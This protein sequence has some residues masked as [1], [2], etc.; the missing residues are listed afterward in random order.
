MVLFFNDIEE[1]AKA[2]RL[3]RGWMSQTARIAR[4][5]R[6]DI[7]GIWDEGRND[8]PQYSWTRSELEPRDGMCD[9]IAF[10]QAYVRVPITDSHTE[11]PV[12]YPA[13]LTFTAQMV[14]KSVFI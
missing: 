11:V 12:S 9:I 3:K 14:R 1:L 2:D 7:E 10:Q 13:H 6:P 5:F 4:D 8:Y